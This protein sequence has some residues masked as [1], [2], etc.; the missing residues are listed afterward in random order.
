MKKLTFIFLIFFISGCVTVKLP[1]YL[2]DRH[3]YRKE[4]FA[5]YDRIVSAT[6]GAVE[7]YGWKISERTN[8]SVFEQTTDSTSRGV[9]FFTEVRETPLFLS[10]KYIS[11]NVFLKS[12]DGGAAV[13]IRYLSSTPFFFTTIRNYRNDRVAQNIFDQINQM[14]SP[15]GQ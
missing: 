15:P 3:P 2:Q 7:H 8:P 14:L 13:E 10:S 12:I 6:Q 9:L 1:K 11:L 5:D 4:F